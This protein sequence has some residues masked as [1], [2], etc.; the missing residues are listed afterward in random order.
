M[1]A[2][3]FH[4]IIIE[5]LRHSNPIFHNEYCALVDGISNLIRELA[6]N[7][8]D[9]LDYTS[10]TENYDRASKQPVLQVVISTNKTEFYLHIYIHEDNYFVIKKS[11]ESA[12]APNAKQALLLISEHVNLLKQ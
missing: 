5:R 9:I 6:K 4:A 8:T 10:F 3:A 7:H 11:G 2:S 12:T 1:V